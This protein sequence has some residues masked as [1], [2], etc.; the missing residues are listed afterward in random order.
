MKKLLIVDSSEV[1]AESLIFLLRRQFDIRLCTDSSRVIGELETYR[2]DFL[3]INIH[4]PGCDGITLLRQA[5]Y[6]PPHIIGLV[7]TPTPYTVQTLA[8]LGAEH[9]LLLPCAAR[10]IAG[11]L[12]NMSRLSLLPGLQ[13]DPRQIVREHLRILGFRDGQTGF[14]QLCSAALLFAQDP[15]Q[16]LSKELQPAVAQLCGNANGNQVESQI[17]RLITEVWETRNDTIWTQYFPEL[18]EKPTM[19]Q[20]LCLLTAKLDFL[21]GLRCLAENE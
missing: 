4:L 7:L 11:H 18:Q 21:S 2:P 20:F 9:I 8:D 5:G 13:R 16:S 14:P 17:R 12:E 10:A 3:V 19:R 15:Y 1:L 6:R